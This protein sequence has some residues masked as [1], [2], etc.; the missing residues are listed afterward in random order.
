M[1]LAF[2]I[3]WQCVNG[4][5]MGYTAQT[6]EIW[7]Q[8]RVPESQYRDEMN[9][10]KSALNID[11]LHAGFIWCQT[12]FWCYSLNSGLWGHPSRLWQMDGWIQMD[13]DGW[14]KCEN[15]VAGW[16]RTNNL[17]LNSWSSPV[18]Q[19]EVKHTSDPCFKHTSSSS[20]AFSKHPGKFRILCM[21]M[22]CRWNIQ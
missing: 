22:E 15:E 17:R 20:F 16:H 8:S 13:S 12:K 3:L 5:R 1:S 19:L 10:S 2:C 7:T 18:V 4:E 11:S 21:N 9:D 6:K 14:P